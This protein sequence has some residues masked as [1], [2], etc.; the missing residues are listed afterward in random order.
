VFLAAGSAMIFSYLLAGA[1]GAQTASRNAP[2]IRLN[3]A[4]GGAVVSNYIEPSISVGE[5]AYVFVISVD[6]DRTVQVLHPYEPGISVR[7]VSGRQL[8][9][10]RFFAGFAEDRYAARGGVGHA[11]FDGFGYGSNDSRGTL[12]GL[13]S[14]K[15]FNLSALTLGG[16]WDLDALRELVS[17]RDPYAAASALARYLGARGEPIGRDVHR[18]AGGRHYYNTSYASNSYYDCASYYG[19]LGYARAFSSGYGISY[20]RAAQLRQAGY[21]VNFIGIDSCGQPRFVV[22]P[23]AVAGPPPGRP[24]AAGAFP[25]ARLPVAVPRNP[26]KDAVGAGS[27]VFGSRPQ[28]PDRNT[29]R[30]APMAPPT[31]VREPVRTVEKFQP[32]PSTGVIYERPRVPAE[33]ARAPDRPPERIAAP[34]YIPERI[35]P[36]PPPPPPRIERVQPSSPKEPT[37][38][39]G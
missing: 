38:V 8:Q 25:Q 37:P 27:T 32:P 39:D 1:A 29:E 23:F 28:M 19:S 5:D 9:L 16:D 12:I 13:A 31:R 14:R 24:P 4:L 35:A 2:E 18:F 6:L 15:P 36:P 17:N 20:F 30:E 34:V 21:V 33:A 22:H 10:P 3:T 11:A 26:T 7:M